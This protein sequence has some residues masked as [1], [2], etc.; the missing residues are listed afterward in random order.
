MKVGL[1][2]CDTYYPLASDHPVENGTEE[3][4]NDSETDEDYSG[5]QLEVERGWGGQRGGVGER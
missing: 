5:Y 3:G 4:S 2:T 1:L